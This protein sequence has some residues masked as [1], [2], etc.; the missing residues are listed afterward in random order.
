MEQFYSNCVCGVCFP[1]LFSCAWMQMTSLLSW[2]MGFLSHA[3]SSRTSSSLWQLGLM[4]QGHDMNETVNNVVCSNFHSRLSYHTRRGKASRKDNKARMYRAQ[5]RYA[6]RIVAFFRHLPQQII[7]L[8]QPTD[9][10]GIRESLQQAR[11]GKIGEGCFLRDN[12]YHSYSCSV[13]RDTPLGWRDAI[14]P[15]SSVGDLL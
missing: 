10:F 3:E 4:L 13:S 15:S 5:V 8:R 11:H 6:A 2:P 9:I 1:L 14:L 12:R 7:S